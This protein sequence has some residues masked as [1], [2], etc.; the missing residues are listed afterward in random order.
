MAIAFGSALGNGGG[1]GSGTSVSMT[2]TG[3]VPS[4]GHVIV[5]T[6]WYGSATPSIATNGGG[7][8]LDH[9]AN[10][11][12]DPLYSV[13]LLSKPFPSGLASSSTIT[14]DYTASVDGR[15]VCAMY[16]TG[17]ADTAW[18]D[19][20][21][22]AHGGGGGGTGWRVS[23]T[24]TNAND[25]LVAFGWTGATQTAHTP[26]AGSTEVEDFSNVPGNLTATMIYRIETVTG[27]YDLGSI[28]GAA[29]Q[30][31]AVGVAYKAGVVVVPTVTLAIVI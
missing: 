16:A 15:T 4:G 2:T 20:Q 11:N 6:G 8:T 14:V 27:T 1:S 24:T 18:E 26:E 23:F 30:G 17:V 21:T 25:L 29:L 5:G 10:P 13:A 19:V 12:A 9:T 22:S 31:D 7:W 3:A 28:P